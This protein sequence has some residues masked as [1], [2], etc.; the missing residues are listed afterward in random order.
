VK[1]L[2]AAG[3]CAGGMH[4]SN[5]LGGNSLSDLLVFGRIAGLHAA[6]YAKA[7]GAK[8][9]D[10]AQIEQYAR[11]ALEPFDRETGKNPFAVHEDLMN[12]MQNYCGIMRNET[13]LTKCLSELDRLKQDAANTKIA[14]GNRH[15]NTGWH[16]VIDLRNMLIVSEAMTRSALARKESRGGH[17]RDDYPE[18][19]DSFAKVN[20]V[21]RAGGNGMEVEAVP[22]PPV[23]DEIKKVL[24]EKE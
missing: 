23:P 3:E 4:G 18:M 7:T 17:A 13:D 21:A 2:F 16:E 10:A 11:E 22:L 6:K 15:Y 1:G 14:G 9:I 8:S 24:E 12:V 20:H 19:I 5:R